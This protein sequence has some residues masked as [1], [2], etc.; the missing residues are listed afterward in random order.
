MWLSGR[1]TCNPGGHHVSFPG[2]VL[3]LPSRCI[4]QIDWEPYSPIEVW[5]RRVFWYDC[6][7]PPPRRFTHP[8][9][10]ECDYDDV[11]RDFSS[12]ASGRM[13]SSPLGGSRRR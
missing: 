12:P 1:E 5:G 2:G 6:M 13:R 3:S 11:R 4:P 7:D 9:E 10:T 8:L